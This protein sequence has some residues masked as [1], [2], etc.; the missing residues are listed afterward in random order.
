MRRKVDSVEEWLNLVD[1]Y[2]YKVAEI[3]EHR[4][5]KGGLR[6]VLM[7]R[8][9]LLLASLEG[10]SLHR[11]RK[12]DKIFRNFRHGHDV[13]ADIQQLQADQSNLDIKNVA[14][15]AAVSQLPTTRVAGAELDINVTPSLKAAM[16]SAE[17]TLPDDEEGQALTQLSLQIWRANLEDDLKQ[18]AESYRR[19][20]GRVTL[21]A[22][23]A[24]A[25]N[26]ESYLREPLG[27]ADL[28]LSRFKVLLGVPSADDNL[29]SS[30]NPEVAYSIVY[31]V[32]FGLL[33]FEKNYGVYLAAS[34]QINYWRRIAAALIENPF[35]GR[36]NQRR[37]GLTAGELE[38]AIQSAQREQLGQVAKQALLDK[39]KAQYQQVAAQ[40]AIERKA[41]QQEQLLIRQS[42]AAFFEQLRQL[43][44]SAFGGSGT[45]QSMLTQVLNAVHPNRRISNESNTSPELVLRLSR[46]GSAQVGNL[47]LSWMPQPGGGWMLDAGGAEYSLDETTVHIPLESAHIRVVRSN[48]YI[49]IKVSEGVNRGLSDL[50]LT[51]QVTSML[52]D[53]AQDFFNLRCSRGVISWLRDGR[54]DWSGINPQSAQKYRQAPPETLSGFARKGAESLLSRFQKY[55]IEQVQFAFAEVVRL[56]AEAHSQTRADALFQQCHNLSSH[57][58]AH[59]EDMAIGGNVVRQSGDVILVAYRG[60]PVNVEVMGRSLTI[61]ADFGGVVSIVIPGQQA[62]HVQDVL[63]YPMLNGN[64]LVVRQGLRLVISFQS[65]L[66]LN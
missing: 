17:S 52:L 3:L 4:K 59:T 46:P 30:N 34:E 31:N 15:A 27:K 33:D 6:S 16:Q 63:V 25:G 20:P 57:T 29:L 65:H 47:Y 26:V 18:L 22:L 55:P 45:G 11:F 12:M 8:E 54:V 2:E 37:A 7:L 62:L 9:Q 19:E 43:L 13:S 40:E 64:L 50:L 35:V 66:P 21:R 48:A 51:A 56:V 58:K 39:L 49:Q 1:L 5:P 14:R 38:S 32:V 42:F 23:Y 24:L 10:A 28:N 53:P 41:L 61:R 36:N 44:P 60:E